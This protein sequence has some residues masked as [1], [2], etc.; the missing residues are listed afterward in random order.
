M[1]TTIPHGILSFAILSFW[2]STLETVMCHRCNML[3]QQCNESSHGRMFWQWLFWHLYCPQ[4]YSMGY[5]KWKELRPC[6][7]LD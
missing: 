5:W 6:C 2:I 4:F 7:Q 1:W 3:K